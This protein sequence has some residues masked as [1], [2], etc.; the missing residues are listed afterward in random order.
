M[1][2]REYSI[3][4][5]DQNWVLRFEKIR[6]FLIEVFKDKAL[7]IDHVGSTSIPGIKAKPIIDV[8]V[9]VS[10]MEPFTIEREVMAQ[11]GYK[12]GDNYIAPNT[13]LFFKEEARRKTENIHVCVKGSPKARQFI[14]MR[15]YLRN[16]PERAHQYS[17]LKE[18]LNKQHPEDYPAYRA[19][20]DSFLKETEELAY[21][22][23]SA[24]STQ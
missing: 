9:V 15:D 4:A 8:L 19:G 20:K 7:Q 24:N 3:E 1:D 23:E 22:W 16:N 14:V 11:Y 5:Y 2:K 17:E 12:N 21:S 13:I 10:E 18:K 6:L